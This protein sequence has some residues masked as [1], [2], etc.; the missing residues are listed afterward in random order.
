MAE[1]VWPPAY[2]FTYKHQW[3]RAAFEVAKQLNDQVHFDVVHQLT[4]V[5]FRVP[6]LLWKLDAPFVW[7]R[8][9]DSNN[10]MA[11]LPH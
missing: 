4:Y 5:G 6:G 9:E 3:Q 7:V 10:N 1:K 8:S 2:L 11:L